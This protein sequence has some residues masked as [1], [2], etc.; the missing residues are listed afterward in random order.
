M[1]HRQTTVNTKDEWLTPMELVKSLGYFALDPCA[2]EGWDT[3]RNYFTIKDNGLNKDWYGRVWLNPPF[4]KKKY[5]LKK[6][7]EHGN[8]IALVPNST[9]TQWFHDYCFNQHGI[10]FVN[11]RVSFYHKNGK[12]AGSPTFGIC[13]VAYSEYDAKILSESNRGK[14]I[15]LK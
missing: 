9:D 6:M 4:S 8:G 1:T 7:S 3:A 13:L 10:L 14:F 2:S 12:K 15:K 11:K 5:W